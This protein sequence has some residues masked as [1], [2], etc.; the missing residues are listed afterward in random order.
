MQQVDWTQMAAMIAVLGG[1]STAVQYLLNRLIIQPQMD[2]AVSKT[3]EAMKIW[4]VEHFPSKASF[5]RHADL[6]TAN[7]GELTRVIGGLVKDQAEDHQTLYDLRDDVSEL[8]GRFGT[9]NQ[10]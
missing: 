6:D 8:K 3:I 4:A 7:L 10:R 1:V 9:K 5:D 2:K